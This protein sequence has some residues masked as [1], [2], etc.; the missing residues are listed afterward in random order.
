MS[1][2]ALSPLRAGRKITRIARA[3]SAG[4]HALVSLR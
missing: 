3:I 1:M 2:E 4:M